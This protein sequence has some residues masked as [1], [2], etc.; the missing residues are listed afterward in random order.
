MIS[1]ICWN[2]V[3]YLRRMKYYNTDNFNKYAFDIA[4]FYSVLD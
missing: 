4:R 3:D 1:T 2:F